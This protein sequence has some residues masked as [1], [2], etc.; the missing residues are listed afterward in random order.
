MFKIIRMYKV[1]RLRR[2]LR[3]YH[4]L[5]KTGHLDKIALLNEALTE[6]PLNI[7]HNHFSPYL[8]G[9]AYPYAPLALRQY[10]L[11]R[12]AGVKLNQALLI[13]LGKING[14]VIFP[15]PKEWREIISQHGFK[16]ASSRSSILWNFYIISAFL[17]G[18]FQITKI[19]I[20]SIR[21][22]IYKSQKSKTHIYFANLSIN[23]L[24]QIHKDQK[25]YDIISWYLQWSGRQKT[26]KAIHHSVPK[27]SK[28]IA[29]NIDLVYQP[30]PLPPLFGLKALFQY[31]GWSCN[32]ILIC[33][34][35]CFRGRWWHLFLLN[36][37]AM[38]AKV[39]MLKK[40][41]LAFE[42]FFHN[43]TWIY[44]PLWTYEAEKAGSRITFYFYSINCEYFKV[45]KVDLSIP[46]GWKATSWRNFL[47]WDEQQA[48]FVKRFTS[49]KPNIKVVGP[50]WFSD[51]KSTQFLPENSIVIFDVQPVKKYFY[52]ISGA[53]F[54]YYIPIYANKFLSDI[55]SLIEKS[56][57]N[58]ILKRK[59]D[60]AKL[61]H[62]SYTQLLKTIS[63]SPNF[64]E[65][66]P[67]FS[68]WR[69]I[70]KASAVISRPYTSTALIAFSLGKPSIYYD[71]SG[72][73][74]NNESFSHGIPIFSNKQKLY[75]WIKTNNTNSQSCT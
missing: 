53:K 39:K 51:S 14:E 73:L 29:G 48:N 11:Q 3:G 57:K 70:D 9:A 12:I 69:I 64:F 71:P 19:I 59:R 20:S 26:I 63:L 6:I 52:C 54:E 35:D 61:S 74:K 13:S 36:Q 49:F 46:F 55:F 8:M 38:S 31:L 56:N 33:L 18:L 22:L 32:A 27:I 23:N 37:F 65:A 60:I 34:F 17:Y 5:K 45:S 47:V 62:P 40:K 24:P 75:K 68:A 44:R 43:S 42:Y 28:K 21:S 72:L 30:N 67:N 25:S 58:F 2:I 1:K 41:S 7:T 10:L 16:V 15:L 66:D 50:I 4:F